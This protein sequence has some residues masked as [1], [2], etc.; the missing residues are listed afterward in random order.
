MQALAEQLRAPGAKT[1]GLAS[2]TTAIDDLKSEQTRL[3]EEKKRL[4][5]ELK[6]TQRR[7]RRL[8]CK[9]RQLTNEDL[10]AVL[11][12]REE[13]ATKSSPGAGSS[14]DEVTAPASEGDAR[15]GSSGD[16]A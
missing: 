4:A 2:L 16:A 3:K 14:T 8:K 9:A 13:T 5:K 1:S 12:M 7:K 6:N 11:L 15:P 10:L